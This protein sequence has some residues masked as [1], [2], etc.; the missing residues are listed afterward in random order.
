MIK[1]MADPGGPA[2]LPVKNRPKLFCRL[3]PAV[4]FPASRSD[5]STAY[6]GTLPLS[7]LGDYQ[8]LWKGSN[9]DGA[10]ARAW[11]GSE[12]RLLS[13]TQW[14][15][16]T[17]EI[18]AFW[19]DVLTTLEGTSDLQ[20]QLQRPGFRGLPFAPCRHLRHFGDRRAWAGR[21]SAAGR[22]LPSWTG[23]TSRRAVGRA[24]ADRRTGG[25][26]TD[27]L[28]GMR[29]VY[30]AYGAPHLTLEGYNAIVA[31]A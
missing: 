21:K 12:S 7:P 19:P 3:I 6:A 8:A 20:R 17:G 18:W 23:G 16:Q 22:S 31:G 26:G 9:G 2:D 1:V 27:R 15:Q 4:P 13:V 30:D 11:N 24:D 14:F 29:R 5:M 25:G 10:A 28:G